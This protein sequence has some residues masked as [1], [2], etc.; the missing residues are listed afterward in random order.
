MSDFMFECRLN[1]N[2]TRTRLLVLR[3]LLTGS[4]VLCG[5]VG[6]AGC[7]GHT[8]KATVLTVDQMAE[9]AFVQPNCTWGNTACETV[10]WVTDN[11]RETLLAQQFPKH[12]S[13]Q[14]QVE[15]FSRDPACYR[16][17][18]IGTKKI[19]Y[20]EYDRNQQKSTYEKEVEP[21][22]VYMKR[23]T[24]TFA[25]LANYRGGERSN[26]KLWLFVTLYTKGKPTTVFITDYDPS[27]GN[28]KSA[29]YWSAGECLRT[30]AVLLQTRHTHQIS[31][32]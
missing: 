11:T 30:V 7:R 19:A 5:G 8:E 26:E 27:G 32:N 16:V 31:S 15:F 18:F 22:S 29:A 12:F 13:V 3:I 1:R 25:S 4:A 23:L 20:F 9:K 28:G 14:A 17:F 21:P 10:R 24:K 2:H 6:L